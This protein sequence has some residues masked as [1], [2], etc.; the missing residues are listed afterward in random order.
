M[1]IQNSVRSGFTLKYLGPSLWNSLPVSVREAEHLPQ[2]KKDKKVF[3][4]E[5]VLI[6][7]FILGGIGVGY[8][9]GGRSRLKGLG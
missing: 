6:F 1:D 3:V 7:F 2:F 8:R 5:L 4:E 9:T